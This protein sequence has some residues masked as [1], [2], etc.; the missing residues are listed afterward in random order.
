M[1]KVWDES[2]P[3]GRQA[4]FTY[5]A[6]PGHVEVGHATFAV[7]HVGDQVRMRAVHSKR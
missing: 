3:K 6:L 5:E 4:G 2:T 7:I 1:T